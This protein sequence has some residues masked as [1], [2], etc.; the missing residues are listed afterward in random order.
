M[1]DFAEVFGGVDREVEIAVDVVRSAPIAE[2][3]DDVDD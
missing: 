3:L 1:G 2:L